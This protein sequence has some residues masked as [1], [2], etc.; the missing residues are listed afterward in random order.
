MRS[1]LTDEQRLKFDMFKHR[2]RDGK[3]SK[4]K[5]HQG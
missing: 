3:G 1:Q 4:G 2:Q 5:K